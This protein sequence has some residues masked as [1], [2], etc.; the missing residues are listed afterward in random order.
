MASEPDDHKR[1]YPG[2]TRITSRITGCTRTGRLLGAQ[3]VGQL[4]ADIFNRINT[5]AGA[6]VHGMTVN[7]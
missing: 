6:V 3:L 2:T 1:Y 5:F 4:G 7:G